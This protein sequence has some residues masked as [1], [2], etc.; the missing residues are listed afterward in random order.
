MKK[1][2]L[3]MRI[4]AMA[5]VLIMTVQIIPANVF[6]FGEMQAADTGIKV[7]TIKKDDVINW[8]IKIYDYLND[9]LLFE[10]AD[11]NYTG[12]IATGHNKEEYIAPYG[13]GEK[14]PV[15]AL[16]SDFTY[17][18]STNY[19]SSNYNSPYYY[20]ASGCAVS[21]AWK[22][23]VDF[24]SPGYLHIT[25]N[26][27]YS[28]SGGNHN[29]LL[30]YFSSDMDTTESMK[31]MVLVYRANKIED[32]YF[33][34]SLSG[35][36]GGSPWDRNQYTLPDSSTWR[37]EVIDTSTFGSYDTIQWVWLT[38]HQT[39]GFNQS[40]QGMNSGA[41]LDLTHVGYFADE[42]E[43]HNYGQACVAFDKNPGEYLKHS[44]GNFTA[45][46]TTV[47]PSTNLRSSYLF[48][49]NYH[50]K[51]AN[52]SPVMGEDGKVRYGMDFTTTSKTEG[53]Y[54]NAYTTNS[55][56]TW[57]N[58]STQTYK[59]TDSN[60]NK[61]GTYTFA[62]DPIGVEQKSES[63]GAMYVR[64][65]S[66]KN[67]KILL[68]KFR[69]DTADTSAV[70]AGLWVPPT[71]AVENLVLVYRVNGLDQGQDRFGLWAQ[72]YDESTA[73]YT[74]ET[75]GRWKYAGLVGDNDNWTTSAKVNKQD[76]K[77]ESGWQYQVISLSDIA[78]NDSMMDYITRI[79]RTG[80]YLPAMEAGESLDLAYVAYFDR[81][82]KSEAEAFGAAAVNYMNSDPKVTTSTSTKSYGSSRVWNSGNNKGFGMLRATGGGNWA[83]TNAGG[84]STDSFG[85]DTWF[86]GY[87]TAAYWGS[88]GN[89]TGY[90]RNPVTGELY[91][92]QY[93][94]TGSKVI[95]QNATGNT[96]N[97]YFINTYGSSDDG[98]DNGTNVFDT[99][100]L[101]F[102]GYEL[103]ETIAQNGV[104][105]VG[106]LEG[107][108]RTVRV[109][110]VEYRVPV[111]RQETVEYI[112]YLVL[113]ALR[114]PQR[115]ANGNYNLAYVTGA[116]STQFGGVD[117]NGDGVIGTIN[118]DGDSRN[119]NE[120]D[121]NSVDLATALRKCL[122][123]SF[124]LGANK[125]TG[126]TL[127]T[128]EETLKK[129]ELL[130]GEFKDCRFSINTAMDAAY[131]LLNS[132]FVAN[133]YNQKQ[134][135]YYY[136]QMPSAELSMTG[137]T[138]TAYVFDAGFTDASN[139]SAIHYS[140]V[141]DA[142]GNAGTG[143]I[144][145]EG[146]A[147]KTHFN[148]SSTGTTW[149][150]RFPFLPVTDAEGDFA[151]GTNSYYFVDDGVRRYYTETGSYYQPNANASNFTSNRRNYNYVMASNGE[152]VYNEK[153]ALFFDFEGDDDVYLFING[154]LVMDNGAGHSITGVYINV[155]DYVNRAREVMAEL[156]D[157]GY[158]NDMTIEKFDE[159]ITGATLEKYV[160][161][162]NGKITGTQTV[163]NPY[164]ADEIA[165]FKRWARLDLCD[166]EVCQFDFY[167][168]ERHGWG[169][170]MRIVTNMHITD[171]SLDVD[172]TAYQYGQEIEYGGVVDPTASLEYNFSLT[173]SGNQKL[174]NLTF[175]DDV[176]GVTL[177]PTNG[178]TVNADKNGIYILD[179][180]GHSLEAKDL[181][182][183]VSGYNAIGS[184][185]EVPITFPEVDGDG[186][187]TALK[188]FLKSLNAEG[189]ES[190]YD[191]AE[192]TH[193]GSG[194]WVDATVTIKG[195]HYMLTP[196]QTKAG[197]VHNTVF[198]TATTRIDPA[199]VGCQTLKSDAEHL[200]YTSGF[201]VHY[202]WAGHNIF[203]KMD[204]LLEGA[205]KEAE[206]AGT[207][208]NLY[209]KF[210]SSVDSLDE[211]YYNLCD[212][213][214]RTGGVY[215]YQ[216]KFTD[217][218]GNAGYLVNYDEPGIY[219]FY[220]LLYKRQ[221]ANK[222]YA[223]NGVDA[224]D[225]AEGEYAI[226][227]SQVYVADVEDSV[228]VLDYGL[229]TESLDLNGELFKNDH[230]FGPYGTVRAKLMGVT[231][232]EPSYLDPETTND[233]DYCRISFQSQNLSASNT[234][235]TSDGV[236]KVNLAIP[237]SGKLISY[238]SAT[239]QYTLTG[240]GTVTI[241]AVVPTDANW[242][243][244]YL[245]YWYDDGTAGPAWP[246]TPM[247]E[248]GAGQ[249]QIDIPAD[250][251]NVIVSNGTGALQT[252][253]LKLTPGL[254]STIYVTVTDGNQV[255]ASI[256]TI[257][258]EVT[259]HVKAPS[260]WE[261]V[262]LHHWHD[263]GESTEYPGEEI[264]SQVDANG[265]LSIQIHGDVTHM[266][267]NDGGLNQS[268][269]LNVYAG[270]E[271][272]IEV[273]DT[274]S[275]SVENEDGTTTTYYDTVVKYT[276]SEGYTVHA[277][278]PQ[279]WKDNVYIYYWHEGMTDDEMNW[280]GKPMTKGEFG[281]YTFEGVPA[282]VTQ[283][284]IN[285]DVDGTMGPGDHQTMDLAITPGLETWIMVNN[286]TT[287]HNG[288]QKYTAKVAYGSESGSTGLT[289]TPK[290]F[291]DEFNSIWLAITVH[292][293]SANPSVLNP[294]GGNPT[295]NIHNETQMY[296]KVSVIPAS[297]VYY[298]DTFGAV[299]YDKTSE[300]SFTH[301]GNGSGRLS[302]SIDQDQPYGQDATYQGGEND[303]Y[304][305]DS[306]TEVGVL[307]A[308][309]SV[310]ATFNFVG[311]GFELIG[312][313]TA[314]DYGSVMVRVY[315]YK[316]Y[317]PDAYA[318]YMAAA[319]EYLNAVTQYNEVFNTYKTASEAWKYACEKYDLAVA[320]YNKAK[321]A[322]DAISP[323]YAAY[324]AADQ[325][326][327]QALK[328]VEAARAALENTG[329]TAAMQEYAAMVQAVYD[330]AIAATNDAAIIAAREALK[331]AQAEQTDVEAAQAA[332]DAAVAATTDAVIVAAR[333][334]LEAAQAGQVD[335]EA[336]KAAYDAANEAATEMR[337]AYGGM[338][339]RYRVEAD[340]AY[341]SIAT[342]EIYR[343]KYEDAAAAYA[344]SLAV[345]VGS[346]ATFTVAQEFGGCVY[347]NNCMD[348]TLF[349]QSLKVGNKPTAPI[350]PEE[351]ATITLNAT[352]PESP[353]VT[354]T[355]VY[356]QFDHGN[357]GGAES[358]NQV[359]IIR[360]NGLDGSD[361]Y[362]YTV[363][364]VA[365]PTYTFDDSF[366][367]TG[368]QPTTLY[369]DG[370]RIYEPMDYYE[371]YFKKELPYND[372]EHNATVE[373]LRDLI[374]EGT[375]GV[376]V[377]QNSSL[378][379]STGTVTWT[380]SLFDN[381]FSSASQETYDSI[382]VESTS[383][384]LIQGPNNEVYMEGNATNSALIFYVKETNSDIHELQIAVRALDYG[385][386]YGAGSTG[387]SAQLQY[388]ILT[389]SGYA[390]KNLVQVVSGTEQYYSIPYTECPM[391][392]QGRYQIVLRAV[393][394]N[395]QSNAMVS[396]TNVKINGLTV[397][398][399]DNLG[400]GSVIHYENGILVKP[401]Y[402]LVI[403]EDASFKAK[404]IIPFN[405]SELTMTLTREWTYVYLRSTFS[406]EVYDFFSYEDPGQVTS[407]TMW[408]YDSEYAGGSRWTFDIHSEIGNEITFK[409]KQPSERKIELSYC[410]HTY[411]EGVVARE[412]NCSI[413]GIMAYHCNNCD[414]IKQEAIE[415]NDTH[416]YS[417]GICKYC[418]AQEDKY[419]LVGF[420]NGKNHGCDKDYLNMGDYLFVDGKLKVKFEMDSYV[421]LKA[422]G[423][424]AWYMV[425][426]YVT[427]STA[428]FYDT[429]TGD[430]GEKMYVPCGVELLFTLSVN[431][432]GSLTLHYE[433]PCKH[434]W[435][436]GII[437]WEP[438]CTTD[439]ER[440]YTCSKCYQT[441]KEM[442]PATGHN[443]VNGVC[444]NNGC[445]EIQ[446]RTIYFQNT[447][448]WENV[449]LYSWVDGGAE[450]SSP[451]PGDLMEWVEGDIYK[452]TLPAYLKVIFNNGEGV[453]SENQDI[454]EYADMFVWS[455]K[456]WVNHSGEVDYYLVGSINGIDY[457]F[458]DNANNMGIYKFVDGKLTVTFDKES[459]VFV[460]T[461]G[462]AAWYMTQS[463]CDTY[464]ATLYNTTTGANEKMFVPAGTEIEFTLTVH[465]DDT[466]SLV[467]HAW[468][469]VVT[470]E[471]SCTEP[472]EKV[473]TCYLCNDSYKEA[474]PVAGHSFVDDVC[475]VCGEEDTNIIYFKN[476]AG[477]E[478]VY[479]YAFTEGTPATEY[480][481]GWPGSA[482]SLVEGETDLYYYVLSAKAKS[483]IFNNG[484]GVQTANL[485]APTDENNK[486]TYGANVWTPV[487][488]EVDVPEPDVEYIYFD[489]GAQW[490][491]DDAWFAA[492]FFGDG[493]TWEKLTDEDGDGIYRC[494]KPEGYPNVI[495]CRMNK[496]MSDLGWNA[497]WNQTIDLIIP[498]DGGNMFTI[499]GPWD[500]N[501]QGATGTW[502][503]YTC[504]HAYTEETTTEPG[505]ET[506][507]EKTYTCSKCGDSYTEEI[508][509]TGHSYENG[510]CTVCGGADPDYVSKVYLQPG[511][512]WS[513]ADAWFAAWFTGADT[514]A[515]MTDA[516]GNG[517]YSCEI[518]EGATGV[519][520]V[521][522]NPS[523]TAPSWNGGE[524]WNQ[525]VDLSVE[526][527]RLFVI[528]NPWNEA[529]DWKAT[530]SWTDYDASVAEC[531]H[532]YNEQI[533]TAA[534]CTTAGSKTLT[535]GNCGDS[536][537]ETIPATGHSF[538]GGSCSICGEAEPT[539][540][541]VL[542]LTPNT[543]WKT[544]NPWYCAYFFGNG[545]TWVKMTDTNADGIYECEAPAGYPNV[546]FCRMNPSTSD[547]GW[548][549]VW[550][551]TSDLTVPVGSD[552]HYTVAEG[553][554]SKGDGSWGPYTAAFSLR[555]V[556]KAAQPEITIYG[557]EDVALNLPSISEQMSS[558]VVYGMPDVILPG[559]EAKP[560]A[561]TVD[562]NS[563]SLVLS[564]DICM[565]YYVTVPENAQNVYMTFQLNGET[566]TV[567][568]YT[569]AEDGRYI[570]RFSGINA[571]KMGDDICATVYATVEG[572]CYTDC[573]AAYSVRAYCVSQLNKFADDEKLVRLIS[574][575]LVYG[576]KNQIYQGY[577][578]DK[579]VTEGLELSPSTFPGVDESANRLHVSGLTHQGVRYSGVTLV[580][581][582]K[583]MMRL[584][585][586]TDDPSAFTYIVSTCGVDTVYTAEDLVKSGDGKYYL[587]F[588]ALKATGFNEAVT[589]SI[590]CDGQTVSQ[591][592]TYSVNSYI[593]KNQ[594]ADDQALREL[595][596]AIYNYGCSAS[597]YAG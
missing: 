528:D 410:V 22:D 566:T 167:Y 525:T 503:A 109:G 321:A 369:I 548:N 460:K 26:T 141:A 423:N 538:V 574:D 485:R 128:Y 379:L 407:A 274:E 422:D 432:D 85:Y 169:A 319:Q 99:S 415:T 482:M 357:D 161:D 45:T 385:R 425:P 560:E 165:N 179:G 168:M 420:I 367:I 326:K 578:T 187:Q 374:A 521:R 563:A 164:S 246:G 123:I 106:M 232:I 258:E 270:K 277:T 443:F 474:I 108:L 556:K 203:V 2:S 204:H 351:L 158:T 261:K 463:Y 570:F 115:D 275:G 583:V 24:K 436:T 433:E 533:N 329:D 582:N 466:L 464:S 255:S 373:E 301:H 378:S 554:W 490:P 154:E 34:I 150:T 487:D 18:S 196:E 259:I 31:Y 346:G 520:F 370:I 237:D 418:G 52:A 138:G 552:V 149:T 477:W 220:L 21:F 286:S 412:P 306:L 435:G 596:R 222:Y 257:V 74:K 317:S 126:G 160:Y 110:N 20:S 42:A 414:H 505:C 216:S 247:K 89:A 152:F 549:N 356:T 140:P 238:D 526:A 590:Q 348:Y 542:Y 310:V 565:N 101:D 206:T 493:D 551:Q 397:E 417:G 579:L 4:L 458:G 532:S 236:Y 41:Y 569:V 66:S 173:N 82:Q 588:D 396:Y 398:K 93:T 506:A 544:D 431:D 462:N 263:N 360:V 380:E 267:I 254:E 264:T 166:G 294:T 117:L 192:V 193:A 489:P 584:T 316:D 535:C 413:T 495:F 347:I 512:E 447:D 539:E 478:N 177:D 212:K 344:A 282:D 382:K 163:S 320:Q 50:W 16:G 424:K 291:M 113:N 568:D 181:T 91:T 114:V 577:K 510:T 483:V 486:Y 562:I 32:Y 46:T 218:A 470:K 389:E 116:K 444:N 372:K 390:W 30:N 311:T 43:A 488:Q 597:D 376:G 143:T 515:V 587:Y 289:F 61:T 102:D 120:C 119:G 547:N 174:Y 54:T 44:S 23:A 58:G 479:I 524:K 278:V 459:Y 172:K 467:A 73:D 591:T 394:P 230:L 67:S 312:R 518:P 171:P 333:K 279:T 287:E 195:I 144:Y 345:Q 465:D 136:L 469:G 118:L 507:G 127:G 440:T 153:D 184:Y 555:S 366:N 527:N 409:I 457:G 59:Y 327:E 541:L 368:V 5:L 49:L 249:Y 491:S 290:D 313:T 475:T 427:D 364:V 201:P 499:T 124:S 68:S 87:D 224:E 134:D 567:T 476:T 129:D 70:T 252:E 546:I 207:Q 514:W 111:Y 251:T 395:T 338:T 517:Y 576:E 125:G 57:A 383:D 64:L 3:S 430:Y 62:M 523:V 240:V 411:G 559:E 534:T 121:E 300:N 9:G 208:L 235:T 529:S 182:A 90:R 530:G 498:T 78:E 428:T 439:G 355:M 157:Y 384:Y 452:A 272:W 199:T 133:S 453:Q 200:I 281:W 359:P 553:A 209:N 441:K 77:Y 27:A 408:R 580:L 227:R 55:Y 393:N 265:Y 536:Y 84:S 211:I 302:Q 146:V 297:V 69:E 37:Y 191:D 571:Q 12:T 63:N 194:L 162:S 456:N 217:K 213:Y 269:D 51:T 214:G 155:N 10:Y 33:S 29:M 248:L 65:T 331:A 426:S 501:G 36:T 543:N 92:A 402:E 381:D 481:G 315:K 437:T 53:D 293:T 318:N 197:Q 308:E 72:G 586:Q 268:G 180:T 557:D 170:N 266:L 145:M 438:T 284:V 496:E 450:Y 550:N 159:M 271:V 454:P 137:R 175:V 17:A 322:R 564:D 1:T 14:P 575:L 573:V 295:I 572:V 305:G 242:K 178:L 349:E 377:M 519:V 399:L 48:S 202:Q 325:V 504:D 354:A 38:F 229:S 307:D 262:Y 330:A 449:Y 589:A 509:A 190:G 388:G 429:T 276:L 304:S 104:L 205:K 292:S 558:D 40:Y 468:G 80:L 105:T 461:T 332:Y 585:V 361:L 492:Y 594:D 198:L 234:I 132:L 260:D 280:P 112:A 516:A 472:G 494:V 531:Q 256:E 239:G 147:G 391:D 343:R 340:S 241:S 400:E 233:T 421:Y 81:E 353:F 341:Y 497:K 595:V 363:E 522:M 185:T 403:V 76:F 103:L 314:F 581:G 298:E 352:M 228:Y 188:N 336:A 60:T 8:P 540:A 219:T 15:T 328:A 283:I 500:G 303:L 375:V 142:S 502:S 56:W 471:P 561:G 245:Y 451:W 19:S 28:G 148:Y 405:G 537:T 480:A 215:P 11:N 250:V 98:L 365:M 288:M 71:S 285:D 296:K 392:T 253:D 323:V 473:Y 186:G 324:Q 434:D 371:P 299:Q 7:D 156:Y 47:S 6:A 35:T 243:Q 593:L 273:T 508:D 339:D 86:L 25:D 335:V 386:Y 445:S 362:G 122:G 107:S 79:C 13:G 337:L 96:N 446:Y 401:E 221:G 592:V 183:V 94:T 387:L 176:I 223:A 131:Y 97:I 334:T 130:I 210:F 139:K 350:A 406:G 83:T 442:I 135:D 342:Y 225:I 231:G 75:V 448:G 151:G 88:G 416:H 309:E 189:T 419:Y 404:E 455:G 484:S 226:V 100:V 244:P 39:A 513:S 545:E 511:S 358:L 95:N